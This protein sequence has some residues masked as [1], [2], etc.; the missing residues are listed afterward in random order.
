MRKARDVTQQLT[1][2]VSGAE[3]AWLD[4]Q[5]ATVEVLDS[6]DARARQEERSRNWMLVR[7]L[8]SQI[9]ADQQGEHEKAQA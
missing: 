3:R 9:Q 5:I 4:D 2:R 8:R 7:L 6:V 1:I